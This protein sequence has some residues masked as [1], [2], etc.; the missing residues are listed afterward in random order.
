MTYWHLVFYVNEPTSW[1]GCSINGG[2]NQTIERNPTLRFA[3]GTY[4]IIVYAADLCG[5]KGASAPSRSLWGQAKPELPM[6][7]QHQTK[8]LFQ[9]MATLH[10]NPHIRISSCG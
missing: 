1:T 6:H 4:T 10:W 9:N 7:L 2:A 3:Y 8:V 5:N